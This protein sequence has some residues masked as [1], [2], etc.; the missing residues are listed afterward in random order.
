MS[1]ISSAVN[2]IALPEAPIDSASYDEEA[3]REHALNYCNRK[4]KSLDPARRIEWALTH[5]PGNHVLSSSFGTQ[6]AVSLHLVTRASPG[7]PVILIDTGYLFPE[8]Y[9]FVDE[10][11]ERL[12]LNLKV[13]R[14]ERSTAWQ[15]AHHGQRWQQGRDGINAYNEE[16]KVEPMR[17]ALRELG[18]G[19]W[20]A[21]LRRRQSEGR[22]KTPYLKWSGGRWKVHPIADWSDRDVHRYLKRHGLP[23]HPLLEKGYLSIGDHHSTRPIHEVSTIEQTR[24]FGLQREC[25]IHE[26]DL[27]KL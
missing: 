15:E 20:F 7:I 8:T 14:A 11:T 10:L 18:A 23:Y 24:F 6:A 12:D 2:A 17:R 13:Y 4:F 22:A 19:T 5:L 26:I 9:R 27:A 25:G 1:A 21:G 3:T 16:N